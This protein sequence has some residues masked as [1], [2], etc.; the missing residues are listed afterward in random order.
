MSK[1][2]IYQKL[3]DPKLSKKNVLKLENTTKLNFKNYFEM[4]Y[5]LQLF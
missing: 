1:I 2:L 4:Y 5:F 3:F